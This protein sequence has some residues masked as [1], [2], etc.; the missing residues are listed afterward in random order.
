[1]EAGLRRARL[2]TQFE[3]F[4]DG[5]VSYLKVRE[6]TADI[7]A[8]EGIPDLGLQRFD[9]RQ[10]LH[11]SFRDPLL[12]EPTLLRALQL[13]PSLS[14]RQTT[15]VGIWLKFVGEH[16]RLCVKMPLSAAFPGHDIAE[17]RTLRLAEG[18]VRSFAGPRYRSA[19]VLLNVRARDLRFDL[20]SAFDGAPVYTD[21]PCSAI[22]FPRKLLQTARNADI[23]HPGSSAGAGHDEELPTS[24]ATCLQ[25]CLK[26]YLPDGYPHI[27]LAAEISGYSV[28]SLQR[29]L[30][31]ERTSYAQVVDKARCRV[32]MS[33]LREDRFSLTQIAEQ[34]GYSEHSAFT[35]AFRRWTGMAPSQYRAE[36][37]NQPIAGQQVRQSL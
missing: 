11:S 33:T 14:K 31:E 35:R 16:V 27:G 10:V 18:V 21:E 1:M 9:T 30:K 5:W 20:E 13:M 29:R 28:R 17:T 32:A 23:A 25:S 36:G 34:L 3:Q 19:R 22:E 6:F 2:P 37:A 7:A 8:R 26:P 12:M 24:V 15:G 4:P